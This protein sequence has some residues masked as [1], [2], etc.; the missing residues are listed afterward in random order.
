MEAGTQFFYAELAVHAIAG[1]HKA[2]YKLL[3]ETPLFWNTCLGA[4]QT[5]TF[6]ALGRIFDSKSPH[7]IGMLLKLAGSNMQMFSK[8]GLGRRKQGNN[9]QPP[10]WLS[11]YL[12]DAYEPRAADFSRIAKHVAH[13]RKS[14]EARYRLLRNKV[15]AHKELTSEEAAPHWNK[16]NIREVQRLFAFL[17]SLY[18]ALWQ[19]FIN[20]RKPSL[21]PT[22]YSVKQMIGSPSPHSIGKPVQEKITHEAQHFL[23]SASRKSQ[24]P[25][26]I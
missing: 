13:R 14:Y 4:L 11:D 20:G 15:I 23:I 9:P 16:T 21:R 24:T 8:E 5:A 17:N 6:I 25:C 26:K 10:S 1:K 22:R 19:L 3:N 12:R 2:V 18:E 7:N